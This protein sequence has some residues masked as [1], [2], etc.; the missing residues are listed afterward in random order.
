MTLTKSVTIEDSADKFKVIKVHLIDRAYMLV[1]ESYRDCQWVIHSN[2]DKSGGLAKVVKKCL[3]VNVS[4][5]VGSYIR[6]K[7]DELFEPHNAKKKRVKLEA[8]RG[9]AERKKT[10]E[11]LMKICKVTE[12]VE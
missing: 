5:Q 10:R 6:V 3:E 11:G 1:L 4:E 12:H 9:M 8:I 2:W 7:K